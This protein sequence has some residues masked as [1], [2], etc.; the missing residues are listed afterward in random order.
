[1]LEGETVTVAPELIVTVADAVFEVSATLVAITLTELGLSAF[2]GAVYS[3]SVDT[4]PTEVLPPL[5]PFTVQVTFVLL[6]PVTVAV[7][8]WVCPNLTVAAVGLIVIATV[9]LLVPQPP[10]HIAPSS[11]ALAHKSLILF[12]LGNFL[13]SLYIALPHKAGDSA[14][15]I[16]KMCGLR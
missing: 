1:M 15:G 6:L 10:C 14:N 13:S 3:P 8:C 7:N 4:V 12:P 16:S 2:T 5:T 11:S 9:C